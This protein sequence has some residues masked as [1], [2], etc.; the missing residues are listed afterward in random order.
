MFTDTLRLIQTG[1]QSDSSEILN[2]N[3][4][5]WKDKS[6]GRSYL[7]KESFR[8]KTEQIIKD[9]KHFLT[10]RKRALKRS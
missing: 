1:N 6:F 5:I 3:N 7:K 8:K 10:E 9:W 2:W 4:K